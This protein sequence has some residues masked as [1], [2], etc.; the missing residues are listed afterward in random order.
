MYFCNFW[1]VGID[2]VSWSA[3]WPFWDYHQWL[4]LS[5]VQSTLQQA[6]QLC[7][8][9]MPRTEHSTVLSFIS[10]LKHYFLL[11]RFFF[12]VILNTFD[13]KLFCENPT[14]D[15]ICTWEEWKGG[16]KQDLGLMKGSEYG[17]I[18]YEFFTA[19]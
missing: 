1:R 10:E 9:H 12:R 19:G 4:I 7:S 2:S 15:K 14:L 16:K 5:G 11:Q 6:A 18:V 8:Q 13:K 17:K 3:P